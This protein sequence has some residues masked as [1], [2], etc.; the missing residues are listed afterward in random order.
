MDGSGP[1]S[2]HDV[3]HDDFATP[4]RLISHSRSTPDAAMTRDRTVSPRAS[5][6]AAD[7]PPRLIRKLQCI[8]ETWALPIRKP[9]QPAASINCQALCPGG[10]LKVDPPVRLLTG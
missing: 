10:F 2:P 3:I 8:S 1:G 5:M 4:I 6:S 7:A 9:R